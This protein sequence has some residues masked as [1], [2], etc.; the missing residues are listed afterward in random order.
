MTT[1]S[2]P[3]TETRPRRRPWIAIALLVAAALAAVWWRT[4]AQ[5]PS[6]SPPAASAGRGGGE[7]RPVSVVLAP[8][9]RHTS[10]IPRPARADV[11]AT[12]PI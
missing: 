9:V 4:R 11:W 3:L 10:T 5:A 2:I 8:T 6:Q 1:E 7:A 12:I